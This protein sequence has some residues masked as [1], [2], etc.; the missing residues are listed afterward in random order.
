MTLTLNLALKTYKNSVFL[1]PLKFEVEYIN[2]Q[3]I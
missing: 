2:V 1:Q 3:G